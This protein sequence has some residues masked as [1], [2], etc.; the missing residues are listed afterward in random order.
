MIL[1]FGKTHRVKK[2]LKF[3]EMMYVSKGSRAYLKSMHV[4]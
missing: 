1:N 2:V 3:M 4:K